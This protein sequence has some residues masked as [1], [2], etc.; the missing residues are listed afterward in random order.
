MV[1]LTLA[2]GTVGAY[3]CTFLNTDLDASRSIATAANG[4]KLVI[5]GS[6]HDLLTSTDGGY[7][8]GNV[9]AGPP[10]IAN[11]SRDWTVCSSSTGQYL[12]AGAK[13][14]TTAPGITGGTGVYSVDSGASWIQ[15]SLPDQGQFVGCAM[16]GGA[17]RG[18]GRNAQRQA[19]AI[20]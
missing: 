3:N 4:E 10:P 8:W 18:K 11:A 15:A 5:G 20:D 16:S 14:Y 17:Y 19:P 7:T 6:N 2:H 12:L 9:Q 1:L 13:S